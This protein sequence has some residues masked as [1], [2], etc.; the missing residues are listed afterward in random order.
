MGE[1]GPIDIDQEFKG[2][3]TLAGATATNA[4]VYITGHSIQTAR[5]VGGKPIVYEAADILAH[6]LVGH[7]IPRTVGSDTGNAVQNENKV[8]AEKSLPLRAPEPDHPEHCRT[9][10]CQ[11]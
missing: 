1:R 8:R 9:Y 10:P 2:G 6:E 5:D 11:N 4:D 3:V 7:A